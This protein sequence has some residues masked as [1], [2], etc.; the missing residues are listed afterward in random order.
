MRIG[1]EWHARRRAFGMANGLGLIIMGAATADF[2]GLLP[3]DNS[4]DVRRV[5]DWID[6]LIAHESHELIQLSK[7]QS[8]PESFLVFIVI[9]AIGMFMLRNASE[10]NAQYHEAFPRLTFRYP[11]ERRRSMRIA[12]VLGVLASIAFMLIAFVLLHMASNA[13]WPMYLVE[14]LRK[15]AIAIGAW[16]IVYCGCWLGRCNVKLYNFSSLRFANIY[17]IYKERKHA[18]ADGIPSHASIREKT[19]CDWDMNLGRLASIIAVLGA[20]AVAYLDG[21][22]TSQFW[23]PIVVVIVIILLIRLAIT[24]YAVTHFE[25]IDL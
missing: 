20:A 19:L 23:L 13:G 21:T 1:Y 12:H 2:M 10:D 18:N 14:G 6:E 4:E 3:Q 5:V 24:H 16:V 22:R 8:H 15:T 9:A 17:E 7:H 25:H 11:K